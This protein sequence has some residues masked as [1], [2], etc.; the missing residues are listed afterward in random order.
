MLPTDVDLR[1][2]VSKIGSDDLRS[3]GILDCARKP[4]ECDSSAMIDRVKESRI[5]AEA[6]PASPASPNHPTI[7]SV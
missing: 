3:G 6:S 7:S 2:D 4:I 1:A 5:R